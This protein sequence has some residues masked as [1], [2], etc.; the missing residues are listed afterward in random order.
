MNQDRWRYMEKSIP[1]KIK[2]YCQKCY[3]KKKIYITNWKVQITKAI[4]TME[5]RFSFSHIKI[6]III[7]IWLVLN[8]IFLN[9]FFATPKRELCCH[10]FHTLFQIIFLYIQDGIIL[11]KKKSQE[12]T[13]WIP[14][15]VKINSSDSIFWLLQ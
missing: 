13:Q 9:I 8:A 5:G 10:P 7:F 4:T 1:I 6:T 12:Q 15:G 3:K 11:K 2:Q 14:I